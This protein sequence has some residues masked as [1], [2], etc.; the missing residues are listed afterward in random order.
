VKN[1]TSNRNIP[2]KV[3]WLFRNKLIIR[4]NSTENLIL[5]EIENAEVV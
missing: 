2:E 1:K 3:G 4:T 5:W